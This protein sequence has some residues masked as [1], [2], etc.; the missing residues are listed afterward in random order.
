VRIEELIFL[1]TQD[2]A[3]LLAHLAEAGPA[4]CARPAFIQ[5]LRRDHSIEVVTLA[6][7]L[8]EAR[9]KAPAKFPRGAQLYFTPELLEQ[10]SAHPPAMHRARRF[11]AL[12]RV[13]DLGCGGGGDL[14]RLALAGASALGMER[15][16]LALAIAQANLETL[17][18][19]GDLS[20]G[21]FPHDDPPRHDSLFIDPARREGGRRPGG[22]GRAGRRQ[23][24]AEFSPS[25]ASLRPL[26][27]RASNWCI[28]WGP[29]LDLS[30]E[31]LSGEDGPLTGLNR[32]DYELELV[33]WKGE[34]REAAIWG[35]ELSRAQAVAT[36]LDGE[37]D[38]FQVNRFEGDPELPAPAIR[39]PGDFIHEPD[40]SLIRSGLLADFASREN[41]FLL[42]EQIA[43]LSSDANPQSPF[44]RTYKRL[45][46]F[47]FSLARVQEAL[48]RRNIGNLVLKKRGFPLAPEE[49]RKRL[50]LEGDGSAVLI[51]H[52]SPEGHLAHLCEAS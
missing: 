13:L 9:R 34:L 36:V 11:S 8:A 18:L 42:A 52:R 39:A 31:A 32:G 29:A 51:I 21:S 30:H 15:D 33:S 27:G 12:G 24:I 3:A 49:L 28:K 6:L 45:E 46:S 43:Y 44:L 19:K 25:P 48:E 37:M 1:R 16:P 22:S 10:A 35:G 14:S 23:N 4:E 47:P 40:G 26:L 7:R 38:R 50:R 17:N 5:S 2:G 20:L 41:L